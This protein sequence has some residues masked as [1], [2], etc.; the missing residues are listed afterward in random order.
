MTGIHNTVGI[1]I[2]SHCVNDILVQGATPLFFMDY[3]ATGHV[4]PSVIAEVVEGLAEGCRESNCSLLGGE[5][6]EMPG[7][8]ADGEYDLAGFVVGLA[9][10]AKLLGAEKVQE[11]DILI[12]L[13]SSGLHTNGYSLARKLFFELQKMSPQ[14]HMADLGRSLGEELLEPHRILSADQNAIIEE[15]SWELPPIFRIIRKMGRVDQKEMY[16]TFN[17]GIGMILVISPRRLDRV[18][19]YLQNNGHRYFLIG[20]IEKG[21]QKVQIR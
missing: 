16:R 8:Y 5:T 3:I 6:A 14:D 12:G 10:Q 19:E 4:K 2:V 15:G 9:D 21:A 17:M 7:F 13:P 18:Q 1:D 20:E 11:K